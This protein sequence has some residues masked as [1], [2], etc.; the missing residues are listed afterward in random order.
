MSF[1]IPCVVRVY[2]CY[3]YVGVLVLWSVNVWFGGVWVYEGVH[4]CAYSECIKVLKIE[5]S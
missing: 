3:R 2:V 4:F 1:R 5:D